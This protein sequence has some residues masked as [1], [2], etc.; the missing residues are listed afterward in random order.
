[1][2]Q[3]YS[4]FNPLQ[5]LTE[6]RERLVLL[7]SVAELDL[8]LSGQYMLLPLQLIPDIFHPFPYKQD[9]IQVPTDGKQ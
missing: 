3:E 5:V 4:P 9:K 2:P 8:G 7:D 6:F 1:M